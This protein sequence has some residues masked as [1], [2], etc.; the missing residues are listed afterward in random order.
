MILHF[1]YIK[2]LSKNMKLLILQQVVNGFG[3]KVYPV[4]NRQIAEHV[5]FNVIEKHENIDFTNGFQ[6]SADG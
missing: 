1:A 6:N 2:D 4:G 3:E 5:C